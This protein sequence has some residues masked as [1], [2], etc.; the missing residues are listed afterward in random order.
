MCS[1]IWEASCGGWSAILEIVILEYEYW[2]RAHYS[3][4]ERSLKKLK[5]EYWEILSGGLGK[6]REEGEGTGK[7]GRARKSRSGRRKR[8]MEYW[9]R[10]GKEEKRREE[11]RIRGW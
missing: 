6:S 8:V 1:R 9:S 5:I 4:M 2:S 10:N 7:H 3:S 11:I